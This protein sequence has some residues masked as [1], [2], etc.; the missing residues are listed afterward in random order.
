MTIDNKLN[1]TYLGKDLEAMSLASNY[2]QWIVDLLSVT[3]LV[4][5]LTA[6]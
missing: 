6:T 5:E 3:G 1:H 4:L 2:N